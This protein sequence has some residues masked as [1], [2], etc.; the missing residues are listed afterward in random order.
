MGSS[1]TQSFTAV[2][3]GQKFQESRGQIG[4]YWLGTGTQA[5]GGGDTRTGEVKVARAPQE[6]TLVFGDPETANEL[7]IVSQGR[8]GERHKYERPQKDDLVLYSR[9][10][11]KLDLCVLYLGGE[12]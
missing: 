10:K 2:P 5:D 8:G 4:W 9:V 12:T 1:I 11:S 6:M 7:E 3:V